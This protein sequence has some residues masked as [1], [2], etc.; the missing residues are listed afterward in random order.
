MLS[1]TKLLKAACCVGVATL[2]LEWL[3]VRHCS[4]FVSCW[5]RLQQWRALIP[6]PF[7]SF[8]S[9]HLYNITCRVV[10]VIRNSTG[11]IRPLLLMT[12]CRLT[13]NCLG[14]GH[15]TQE[16]TSKLRKDLSCFC[17]LLYCSILMS[18]FSITGLSCH[19]LVSSTYIHFSYSSHLV[20]EK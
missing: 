15:Y 20:K 5:Q 3:H 13:L 2:A 4:C 7:S 16:K 6:M 18:T 19:L 8:F 10:R 1:V 17:S 14:W 9:F 12:D 11:Q